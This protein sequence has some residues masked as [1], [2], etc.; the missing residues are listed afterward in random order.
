[1]WN[2][3]WTRLKLS[4]TTLPT[5]KGWIITTI[6]IVLS[7]IILGV[8]ATMTKFVNPMQDYNTFWYKYPQKYM[9]AFL[10]PSF[11]EELFWRGLMLPS[12]P[13]EKQPIILSIYCIVILALHV[14]VH[15]I[16][17]LVGIW[18]RGRDVFTDV[19]FL[20]LATIVLGSATICYVVTNGSVYAATLAHAIPVI[21]WRDCFHGERRLGFGSS[22]NNNVE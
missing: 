3:L 12:T 20:I 22:N 2:T 6:V 17:A 14:A 7:L 4:L 18:P 10:F 21:L 11:L 13:L 1:M 15:P 9:V 19:R 5:Q 16:I 8:I